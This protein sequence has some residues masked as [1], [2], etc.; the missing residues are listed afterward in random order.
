VAFSWSAIGASWSDAT[1][2]ARLTPPAFLP[3]DRNSS[4]SLIRACLAHVLHLHLGG[5]RAPTSEAL[6]AKYWPGDSLARQLVTR[7][8]T[9]PA[10]TNVAGWADTLAV[11]NVAGDFVMGLQ[12]LSG[13]A[14]L[15]AAGLRPDLTGVSSMR[16]PYATSQAA[17]EA[18]W[19]GEGAPVPVPDSVFAT[20]TLGPA[21]KLATI[22]TLTDEILQHS[23]PSIE[24]VLRTILSEGVARGLDKSVFSATAASALRPAGILAGV[25]P[26]TATANTGGAMN[27]EV[28][29][30]DFEN[31]IN[32]IVAAGG[33]KQVMIFMAPGRAIA[34]AMTAP[35]L[36]LAP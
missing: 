8:A 33:G 23:V 10:M 32:A 26:I 6:V 28:A 13:A 27:I 14:Q 3:S 1:S 20:S 4:R 21:K 2:T 36:A 12:R 19:V 34:L 30:S 22:R 5:Q 9:A 15:I 18:V 31:L 16:I 11:Q 17:D 7:A 24:L 29:A 35:G 25:T